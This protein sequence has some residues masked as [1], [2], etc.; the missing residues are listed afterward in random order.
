[1]TFL[2]ELQALEE[3]TKT[4]VLVVTSTFLA[5]I[6]FYFWL[7][8]FSG[9]VLGGAQ[10]LTVDQNQEQAAALPSF[11]SLPKL[12]Q[13]G[14]LGRVGDGTAIVGQ[15]IGGDFKWLEQAFESPREYKIK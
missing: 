4:K 6:V 15:G 1:M 10:S 9:I 5:V 2:E 12:P 8:Y 14:L 3:S 11:S 7:A 13:P